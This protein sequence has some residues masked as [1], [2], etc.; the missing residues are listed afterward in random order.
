MVAGK[1]PSALNKRRK[2]PSSS[3]EKGR[4]GSFLY[5][6]EVQI[7]E[8]KGRGMAKT[9]VKTKEGG[10]PGPPALSEEDNRHTLGC[11]LSREK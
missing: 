8:N 11:G 1:D 10:S 7:L 3:Q 9:T 5:F 2:R 6:L 4:R